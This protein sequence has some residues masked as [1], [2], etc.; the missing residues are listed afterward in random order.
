MKTLIVEDELNVR[1]GFVKLI[2]LF[3]PDLKIVGEAED[4]ESGLHFIQN[5]KIDLLFLD[6]NLPDGSGFDLLHQVTNL[7]F[8]TIFVTAYDQYAINAFKIGAVDYLLKPVSPNLLIKAVEKTNI[9]ASTTTNSNVL[10]IMDRNL[11]GHINQQEKIILRDK[12][13]MH[14][15]PVCEIKYCSA[16]GSYTMFH[17]DQNK[18]IYTSLHLKEYEGILKDYGFVRTHHSYLVNINHIKE[19]TRQDGGLII[20]SDQS[21]VPLSTRRKTGVI[22]AL[23]NRFLN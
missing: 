7:D 19:I 6:I 4:I 23:R 3:C 10:K 18:S 15:I 17:L 1:K 12:V 5:Q 14:I 21:Q 2:Q 8:H 22:N 9:L 13:S 16:D 20:L 11:K